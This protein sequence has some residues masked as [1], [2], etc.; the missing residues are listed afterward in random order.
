MSQTF[1][2][3][4]SLLCFAG[5]LP[6]AS[7]AEPTI[8]PKQLEFFEK[9]IRPVLAEHC[10][11]CH[12]AAEKIKGGLRLDTRDATLVGGDTGPAIEP[13]D[14]AASLLVE[15]IRWE[16]EDLQM[17]PKSQ[18]KEQEVRDLITWIKMGAPDPRGEER[19]EGAGLTEAESEIDYEAGRE[20][21]IYQ[22]VERPDDETDLDAVILTRLA[23]EGLSPLGAA[24]P[25]VLLRRLSYDLVGLPPAPEQAAAFQKEIEEKG[26]EQAV[27]DAVDRLLD[28]SQFGERWGRHWLDVVRYAES[29]G[30]ERNYLF[31]KA[32]RYR[33]YVIDA[34]NRD[35]PFD[36]FARE[37]V[38]GDLI[39]DGESRVATGFLAIG[40]KMLNERDKEVFGYELIDEQI[41]ATSRAFLGLTVSC[42]RCH[43][44]K[45]DAISQSDYYAMAGIFRST[46]TLFGGQGGGG[47]RQPSALMP[48]G[49]NAEEKDAALKAYRKRV[50]DLGKQVK[51]REGKLRNAKKQLA[52]LEKKKETEKMARMRENMDSIADERDEFKERLADLKDKAP[53][54]PEYAMGVADRETPV[55]S[56]FLIRGNADTKAKVVPR[57]LPRVFEPLTGLPEINPA[58][59]GR[60]EL[61]EWIADDANPLTSRVIANRVWAHLFGQGIVRTVDNFG[62][63]GQPPANPELL[64]YL[65]ASLVENGWSLKSLIR[66]IVLS[67]AYQ[68]E[69]GYHERNYEIDPDNRFAWRQDLRRLD[70]E[71]IRDSILAFSGELDPSPREGSVIDG[72]GDQNFG[73]NAKLLAQLDK[74]VAAPHRSVYLPIVRNATPSGLKVFDFAESSLIVGQRNET[75]VPAQALYLMNSGF[76]IRNAEKIAA[77]LRTVPGEEEPKEVLPIAE[78]YQLVLGRDPGAAELRKATE[79]IASHEDPD[80]GLV[81]LCQALIASAEFRYLN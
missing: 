17:P 34:F 41:D 14:P 11:A 50:A 32:W 3:L 29:N 38:A 66:E 73:R 65:A 36:Q 45:F 68:R 80:A 20:H 37:Q 69:S 72:M 10:Y 28:S 23:K 25:G 55:D 22:P 27:A 26:K 24:E 44:H 46:Q 16:N 61:A 79:L 51:S 62:V 57:G 13:G 77:R 19:V 12:S 8:P 58:S 5:W 9:K 56:P 15:A 1:R 54:A 63:S 49:D 70:A 53:D 39:G 33:D 75:N 35:L 18:L 52:T 81:T 71:A 31:S 42:A 78:A 47:N 4:L 76:V 74:A 2:S 21:W 60:R 48:L 6:V 30:M 40:P 43:D 64:D 59:S 7:L 67:D